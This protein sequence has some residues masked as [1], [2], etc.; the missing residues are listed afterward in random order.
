M[1]LRL[2]GEDPGAQEHIASVSYVPGL[3]S[4]G[5][6][7]PGTR[8][9]TATAKPGTADYAANLTVPAPPSPLRVLRLGLRLQVAID[10]FGGS[11]QATQLAYAVHVNGVERLTGAWAASGAQPAAV[12][13]LEGQFTLGAPTAVGVYLWVDQ[14]N[15]T[16]SAVE[17]WLGVGT[18]ATAAAG[19]LRVEH[20]GLLA[21]AAK[22]MRQ[23]TGTPTLRLAQHQVVWLPVL[24][25]TG[26]GGVLQA[27][28][29][30]A[31]RPVLSALGTVATDLNYVETMTLAWRSAP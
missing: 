26:P 27:P 2:A 9:V 12:D 19:V 23:G 17:A 20:R 6:L 22:L 14:G 28:A 21:L 30:A 13:L 1:A 15:A 25:V 3:A 29:V 18:A 4:S 31:D 11:P 16:V 8:L 7:E 10:G 24:H 5:D